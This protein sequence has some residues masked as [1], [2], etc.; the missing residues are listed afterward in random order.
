M[1]TGLDHIVI[2]VGD[3]DAAANGYLRLLG[4]E[5]DAEAG[6]GAQ[7]RWFRFPNAALELIAA[8]GKG[9]A[10]DRVRTQIAAEGEGVWAIAFATPDPEAAARLLTRRGVKAELLENGG[11]RMEPA[12]TGGRQLFFR[13]PGSLPMS[14][15]TGPAPVDRLDHVVVSTSNP[16]RAL[17]LY[18]AKLGLDLRLDRENAQWGAR[19]MFFRCG[20]AVV[21]IGASLKHPPSDAPDR[22]GGLAWQVTDPEASRARMADAGFNVSELRKGRKPGTQVFTVRD[23]PG[24]VPTLMLQPSP[25]QESP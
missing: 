3:I 18:G 12:D 22:F 17:A 9:P 15:A 11:G 2:A 19:Q 20:E 7:R 23:A 5:P 14:R 24:G 1:I 8:D 6:G 10:G 13:H 16:D 4:V 21:E 25:A